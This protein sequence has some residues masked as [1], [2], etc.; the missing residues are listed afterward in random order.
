MNLK[1]LDTFIWVARLH[2][3]SLAAD[4]LHSTQAAISSRIAVLEEELGARLF[5]RD[6]KGVTL[7]R[8]GERVLQHAEQVTQAMLRL[9]ASLQDQTL[10]HG[11]IRIGAMDS[12]VHTWFVDFVIDVTRKYPN[13]DISVTVDTALH[14]NEHLRKG[15]L[16]V[17]FH[18][19]LLREETIQ[20]AELLQ[21]PLAWVA[22][23]NFNLSELGNEGP[24]TALRLLSRGRLITFS[25]YSR[26]HQD[27]VRMLQSQGMES[28]QISTVNSVAAMIKLIQNDFGVAVMPPALV[29]AELASGALKLLTN[30]IAPPPMPFVMAWRTGFAWPDRLI[31][32]AVETVRQYVDRI[33][34]YGRPANK[35]D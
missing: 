2:S 19:D 4:K 30:V 29:Q 13:L 32:I 11:S 9:R 1:F 34:E 24:T 28:S 17:V 25:R 15:M 27:L 18:T 33:G 6:P 5:T 3:F 7:T 26:P 23:R 8:E 16:D 10:E 14:L 35:P 21:L 20:S 22:S 12:A 31:D